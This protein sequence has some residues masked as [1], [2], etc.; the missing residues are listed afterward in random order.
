MRIDRLRLA[1]FRR[2][3]AAEVEL[4]PG[5]NLFVGENAQ[6]KT[7]LLEAV[8]LLATGRS[9]R[10]HR[11]REVVP[12]E[13]RDGYEFTLAESRF[14]ARGVT[15]E[16]RLVL[17]G[18]EK[19]H[20]LDGKLVPRL[21]DVW[22]VLNVVVFDPADLQLIQGAPA[23]RRALLDGLLA[24]VSRRGLEALQSY[25]RALRQRNALFRARGRAS[26]AEFDAY[27]DQMAIHAAAVLR[28]R[29]SLIDDFTTRAAG[30]LEALAGGREVLALRHEPGWPRAAGLPTLTAESG[31]A[32]LA[33]AL[34]TMWGSSRET[35]L[36]RGH[37]HRGP[38]RGDF[39]I[40]LDGVDGRLY[41]SQGQAR[42]IALALRFAELEL[43][44]ARCGEPPIL[45]LDDVLGELDRRRTE[46]FIRM[47]GRPGI[48]SLLTATD[49]AALESG[50]SVAARFEVNDGAVSSA[51]KAAS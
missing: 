28:A 20:F 49:A 16:S 46:H 10:T 42:S 35:D 38:H 19:A 31:E 14:E 33:E 18:D 5:P 21:G 26:A 2:V 22:G 12:R 27:E 37:T 39:A 45:L 6:G 24:M 3:V 29:Q 30:Q 32:E 4:A 9:F 8:S 15:H 7:T 51:S 36:E 50:L 11:E 25:T 13:P 1:D 23:H 48:Q 17:S 43:I 44:E 41:A 40:L 34:R 47:L